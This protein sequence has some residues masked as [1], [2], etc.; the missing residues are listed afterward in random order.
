MDEKPVDVR[1][2]A[3]E[4]RA[5]QLLEGLAG[6]SVQVQLIKLRAIVRDLCWKLCAAEDKQRI[7]ADSM[8]KLGMLH[9]SAMVIELEHNKLVEWEINARLVLEQ[10]KG[11]ALPNQVLHLVGMVRKLNAR[12]VHLEG[13]R[14]SEQP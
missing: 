7:A 8:V 12:V 1:V 10:A 13:L 9:G 6:L 2:D 11:A 14:D 4:Q 3:W 5:I